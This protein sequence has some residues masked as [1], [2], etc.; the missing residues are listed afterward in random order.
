VCQCPFCSGDVSEDTLLFGGTCPH[1]FAVIP[2]EEAA[3]DPGEAVKQQL[4]S[5]D[6]RR[7]QRRAL[8]PLLVAVPVVAAVA[9]VSIWFALQPAPE[10]AMLDLD[11][12]EVYTFDFELMPEDA[13]TA[14]VDPATP[15]DTATRPPADARVA[16]AEPARDADGRPKIRVA[17]LSGAG[18]SDDAIDRAI[19]AVKIDEGVA[20][21]A[22]T[23]TSSDRVPTS[24]STELG[25][26]LTIAAPDAPVA[27]SAVSSAGQVRIDTGPLAN[28][29]EIADMVRSKLRAYM[30]RLGSCYTLARNSRP[31]LAGDWLL[32]ATVQTD[33]S[34]AG[35]SLVGQGVTDEV[36]EQCVVRQV[37][38]WR[39]QAITRPQKFSKTL[40]FKSR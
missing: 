15:A 21:A 37:E 40:P 38:R 39:F 5:S 25:A 28:E 24:L 4:E 7:A 19:Q 26:G 8:L 14:A 13:P 27:S 32:T 3:T 10:L 12:G 33:G 23:R 16:S 9:G 31:D 35:I 29:A 22:P 30:P 20:D 1:C 17:D 6:R 36:L 2:G 34:V 11:D 18:T